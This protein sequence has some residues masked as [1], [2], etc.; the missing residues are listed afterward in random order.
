MSHNWLHTPDCEVLHENEASIQKLSRQ[1][2]AARLL[3]NDTQLAQDC[4]SK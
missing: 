3:Y 2:L 1:P 4:V